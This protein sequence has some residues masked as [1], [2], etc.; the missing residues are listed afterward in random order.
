MRENSSGQQ[1]SG[2]RG[3][4]ER[5]VSQFTAPHIQSTALRPPARMGHPPD[6]LTV[7][8]TPPIFQTAAFDV[9]GLQ[10]LQELADGT[11]AGHIYTRDSNPNHSALAESIALMEGTPAGAVFAS[12]MAAI[13]SVFLTLGQAG[14]HVVMSQALYG[15]TL[16]LAERFCQQFG[17]QKTLVDQTDPQQFAAACRP[18]TIFAL[19]ETISN[20]LLDVA[21]IPAITRLLGQVPLV[22]DA[23]FTTPELLRCCEHGAAIVVHSASKYLNGHGDVMLGVA[24]GAEPMMKRLLETASIFGS[25][26][27]PFEAWLCQRGLRTLPLRMQHICATATKLAEFLQQ[28]SAVRRVYHPSL[29]T[30]RS[31]DVASRLYPR[32]TGGIVS[33]E[34]HGDSAEVVDRF[35]QHSSAIPFSPTLA[36]ARTTISY[37]AGTSHRFMAAENRMALGIT[38]QL[39]RLS[40][41]LESFEQLSSELQAT[42]DQLQ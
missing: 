19:V 29:P 20:P 6:F 17:M 39:I 24:A 2:D 9:E 22:V 12:G 31:Y 35:M 7:P 37:P 25:N 28:H 33:F 4:D 8:S 38:D 5:G 3:A 14:G 21:D 42:L 15:R 34:L 16:Q 30:H 10:Q 40:V 23:T 27:N 36:D 26:A 32:G 1:N 13:S 11:C 18:E 41:G